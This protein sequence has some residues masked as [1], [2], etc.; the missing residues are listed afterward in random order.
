[1]S[2]SQHFSATYA[3]ARGKFRDAATA[4]GARLSLYR[5]PTRG[6][7]GGELTTDVARLGPD[8]ASR[9]LMTIS[10]T[11]GGE[12]FCGSG[13]QIASFADGIARTL[14]PDTALVVVHAINPHGFAWIRRVTEENVDLNRNFVDHGKTLPRNDWY[15]ELVDAICPLH[16]S[17]ASL[18]LAEA[19]LNDFA[20]QRGTAALQQAISG[21]QYNDPDGIFYG[22]TAP[23]WAR[24]TLQR[25][26]ADNA[27]GVRRIAIIDYHTGLGPYGHGEQITMHGAGSV[28]LAR[29][30]QWYGTVTNPAFGN[31]TSANVQGDILSGLA[32]VLAAQGIEFTGMALEYG[33]VSLREVLDAVRADNWLHHHGDLDSAQ[34]RELKR[35][36][37]DAFYCDKD[38]WKDM[39]V[40]QG[41]RAQRGALAGLAG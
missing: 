40:E 25:I 2:V 30:E 11:H 26:V 22:G 7:D 38:D 21:G 33:T 32:P 23:T 39:V 20:T 10:S 14:P 34:G 31:S 36:M 37:R 35:R 27:T 17:E 12:G 9:L 16:W 24:E 5:N 13:I 15:D 4:A 29:A 6:P 3:E 8:N 19:R 18:A 41:L 28:G 1:M